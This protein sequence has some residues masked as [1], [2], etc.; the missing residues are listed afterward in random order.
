MRGATLSKRARLLLELGVSETRCRI[1]NINVRKLLLAPL[2]TTLIA[3]DAT[4]A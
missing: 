1:A 4:I 2:L 3:L